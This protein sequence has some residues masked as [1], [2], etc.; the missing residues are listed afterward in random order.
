M[1]ERFPEVDWY[2]DKCGAHLNGQ[3]GFDDHKYLWKCT[4]CGFKS[5]ISGTN[6]IFNLDDDNEN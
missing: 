5:S 4:E 1:S 3:A 2:C 6:I